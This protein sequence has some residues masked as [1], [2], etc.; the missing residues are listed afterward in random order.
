[1]S[2]AEFEEIRKHPVYGKRV[3]DAAQAKL[4][5]IS[6]L[7]FAGEMVLYHHEQWDGN[8]YPTGL[9]GEEIPLSGRIMAIADVYDA[10]ISDRPYKKGFPHEKA[11]EIILA[12]RGSQFDPQLVDAFG[13]IHATFK[14]IAEQFADAGIHESLR[15]KIWIG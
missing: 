9:K 11:V 15:S 12:G 5:D 4:G 10:L 14:A 13:E 8:G 2:A 7:K 6:F 3:I 1:M